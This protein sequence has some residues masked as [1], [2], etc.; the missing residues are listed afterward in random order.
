LS[1]FDSI[2]GATRFSEIAV[3][4]ERGPLSLVST[5]EELLGKKGSGCCLENREY[6]RRDPSRLPR[7]TLYP[8]KLE[9]TSTSGGNSVGI[10]RLWTKATEVVCLCSGECFNLSVRSMMRSCSEVK[11]HRLY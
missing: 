8:L 3:G 9:L 4:L 7:G 10:V 1:V 6:C 2:P 5:I 11:R